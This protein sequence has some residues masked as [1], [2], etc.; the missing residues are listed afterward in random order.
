[1]ARRWGW[2]GGGL[3]AGRKVKSCGRIRKSAFQFVIMNSN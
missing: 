1:M 3:H 2:I